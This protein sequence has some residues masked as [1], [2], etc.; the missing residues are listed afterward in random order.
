MHEERFTIVNKYKKKHEVIYE[1]KHCVVCTFF[2]LPT[3]ITPLVSSNLSQDM[4]IPKT[5]YAKISKLDI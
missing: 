2:E 1:N 5:T 3:L 4:F